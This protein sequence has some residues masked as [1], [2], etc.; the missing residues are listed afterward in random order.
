MEQNIASIIQEIYSPE[1]CNTIEIN[2]SLF[3]KKV[4]PVKNDYYYD[5]LIK[6]ADDIYNKMKMSSD[7]DAFLAMDL[8][9]Q[10][11]AITNNT[12]IYKEHGERPHAVRYYNSEYSFLT[13]NEYNSIKYKNAAENPNAMGKLVF[14]TFYDIANSVGFEKTNDPSNTPYYICGKCK[15]YP[16]LFMDVEWNRDPEDKYCNTCS[17]GFWSDKK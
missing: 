11:Y 9:D 13:A 3:K 1:Q 2:E 15:K 5:E 16:G 12:K 10:H 17:I 4:Q 8:D 14:N 6:L 7:K